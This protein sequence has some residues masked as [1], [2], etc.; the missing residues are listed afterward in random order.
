MT[1]ALEPIFLVKN[2]LLQTDGLNLK[3]NALFYRLP[4]LSANFS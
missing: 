3:K 2:T 1:V 4:R